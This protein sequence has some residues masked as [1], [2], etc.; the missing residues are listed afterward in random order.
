MR[1]LWNRDLDPVM[2][3]TPHRDTPA[4]MQNVWVRGLDHHAHLVCDVCHGS[5]QNAR[6]QESVYS[7]EGLIVITNCKRCQ[8]TGHIDV[9]C[10]GI[11]TA[12]RD[13]NWG[14]ACC[15]ACGEDGEKVFV[16]LHEVPLKELP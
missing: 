3:E 8:G 2:R 12:E 10:G 1:F 4:S 15:S 11:G 9:G 6:E 5:G 7:L 14:M 13:I 16:P